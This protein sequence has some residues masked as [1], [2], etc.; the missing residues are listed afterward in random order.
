M[1]KDWHV[2]KGADQQN[3]KPRKIY[4]NSCKN[5]SNTNYNFI[6]ENDMAKRKL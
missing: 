6:F 5:Y 4:N 3:S 1:Y 2:Q